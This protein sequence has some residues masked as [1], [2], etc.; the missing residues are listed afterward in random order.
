MAVGQL[1]VWL[2]SSTPTSTSARDDAL[3][4]VDD[5]LGY[6]WLCWRGARLALADVHLPGN[7]ASCGER[8]KRQQAGEPAS[9]RYDDA[10]PAAYWEPAARLGWLDGAGIDEGVLF[11][12]FGLWWERRLSSSLPAATVNMT[13]WNRWCAV[14]R[15]EGGGRL[16]PVA[17]LTLPWWLHSTVHSFHRRGSSSP[18]K[19]ENAV[20]RF[21]GLV[22]VSCPR[23]LYCGSGRIHTLSAR[24]CCGN[25]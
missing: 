9:Y 23:V 13:A 22:S 12:N 3:S 6:T 18:V 1:A 14:V 2:A 21:R 24:S 19:R 20:C 17:H 8:R 25:G 15:A 4:L 7:A 11:P 10:L 16:H 5:D